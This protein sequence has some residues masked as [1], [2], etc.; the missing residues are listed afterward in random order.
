MFDESGRNVI[1]EEQG[2]HVLVIRD[3]FRKGVREPGKPAVA[4]ADAE[5]GPLNVTG[6]NVGVRRLTR[7]NRLA[8]AHALRGR[9]MRFRLW[10]FAIDFD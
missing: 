1:A 5:V 4:H 9:V 7:D 8:G 6:G 10:A 2:D 3:L